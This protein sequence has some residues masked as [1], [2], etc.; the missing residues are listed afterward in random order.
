MRLFLR[1][2]LLMIA[3]LSVTVGFLACTQSEDG[4]LDIIR[5]DIE[6][7][8]SGYFLRST[9]DSGKAIHLAKDT[10]YLSM[11][12][13]WSFS[14]CALESIKYS[15]S[16]DDSV[17]TIKPVINLKSVTSNCASPKFRPDTTIKILLDDSML[18][19]VKQIISANTYETA[20]DTIKVRRGTFSLD[21]FSI[22]IDSLFNERDSLPIRTKG[23]PS[24]L[25]VLDSITPLQYYW[26]SM[27]SKCTM[28]IS[29]CDSLVSDTLFPQTWSL[30]DTALV[31]VR[32]ACADTE[33]VYCAASYWKNDSSS[34]GPVKEHLDTIWN[35][36]TY[37][38]ESVPDCGTYNRYSYR[39]M[40]VGYKGEFIRELLSPDESDLECGPIS[41]KEWIAVSLSSGTIVQDTDSTEVVEKLYKAWRKAKV[42]PTKASK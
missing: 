11:D 35:T 6:F 2:L 28:K 33:D 19:G 21:T 26:R 16:K 38:V 7:S 36:S 34:L 39:L 37:L 29:D 24:F 8:K 13:V 10:L 25:K 41:R 31:P 15:S 40:L 3:A 42:A 17:L 22:Y 12:S 1:S 32:T 30:G 23:S 9:L 14:L 18:D 27:K 5:E 20:F 4:P